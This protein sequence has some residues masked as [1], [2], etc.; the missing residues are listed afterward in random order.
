M[1]D[2]LKTLWI[3]IVCT[4]VNIETQASMGKSTPVSF[5]LEKI[6][7]DNSS[8]IPS[9][10][11][12]KNIGVAGA[13][14]GCI[15]NNLIIAGGANYPYTALE[16]GGQRIWHNTIYSLDLATSHWTVL[17][18]TLPAPQAY[19]TTVTMLDGLLCIGGC[20]SV[21]SN[22]NVFLIQLQKGK[23]KIA[24]DWPS[25]PVPLIHAAGVLLNNKVYLVGGWENAEI[26]EMKNHFYMLDLSNQ[27]KGWQTLSSWPG[28]PRG[29][30]V[31]AVQND[32]FENCIYLFGGQNQQTDGSTKTLSDGFAY[33]PRLKTWKKLKQQFPFAAGT[34][35][36][37]GVNHILLFGGISD[38]DTKYSH[39]VRIY[40]TITNTLIDKESIPFPIP[41]LTN[42]VRKGNTFYLTSGEIKPGVCTSRTLKGKIMPFEKS[43][44]LVN[45]L[46]IIAYFAALAW[47]GYYFS[48]K[49]KNTNDYFKGGGRLPWWAVGLSIFGTGLSAI[50][51]MSIPAKAYSSDW[52][53]M[54]VNAGI[55]MVTPLV[56]HLFIPFYRKLNVTTAYE[57]L[58]Q[59]FNP[60]IRVICSL[61][62]ILFQIG[63]MGIVM[64][65]PAIALN[66]VTGF[67]LFL[68]IGLMGVLSLAYTMMGGIEAVVWTDALQV[69]V[70]LGGA[71]LVIVIAICDLPEGLSG[72]IREASANNKFGLGSLQFDLQQSTIWTILIATFFTNLTT[73]GTDQTMVQRYMTTETQDQ[74]N[75]SILTNALLIIPATILFFFVGTVLYIY[76]TQNPT[77]LSLTITEGDAILPW[78]IHSRLPDGVS[79]LLISGIFAAA[80]STL[81]SS[82]NSAATAYVM[83]IHSKIASV[84]G[85]L[86]IAKIATLLLGTLGIGFALM[87][88][89]W[90]INS[91]WDQFN[92]ILGLV[93]GS[94][95]G[96]F[97]LGMLTRRAN[98]FGALCGII[99]SVMVQML[100]LY[101]QT[102]HLLLYTTTGFISC[103]VIG[104][105]ASCVAPDSQKKINLV[106]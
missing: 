38:S 98:V 52:S 93:L 23:I 89:T 7:W 102:V 66:V 67:D 40:H 48:K 15:G 1:H 79:G 99:G 83:D 50:T 97:V 42:I 25:L 86:I 24:N 61:A 53:Y 59:R 96:L 76:Y 37:I 21:N 27:K 45:T 39:T 2:T 82:M 91:L 9:S 94:M 74:A 41:V 46:V 90:D 85:S 72:V 103:L 29:K 8:T 68:C 71:I 32:G 10:A 65:L 77:A 43:L 31:I 101:H 49:Q 34:A 75:K 19:G 88:A 36:A 11:R 30:A 69:I 12:Q 4:C 80:M 57:Y 13:F 35:L 20:D 100:V 55:L 63:R 64:Y 6:E 18:D 106:G 3:V 26:P 47:I 105:L 54:L 33:N 60:M 28:T 22:N 62:F 73:Y 70:L 14:S 92:M 58:E 56:I 84:P 95:G 5:G 16:Q 51:F 81:S 17:D 78:Y 104:Y 87:M 44:G